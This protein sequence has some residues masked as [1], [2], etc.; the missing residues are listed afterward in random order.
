MKRNIALKM[1]SRIYRIK[2][3]ED[4]KLILNG[5]NNRGDTIHP[6]VK[7]LNHR[8]LHAEILTAQKQDVIIVIQKAISQEIVR[9]DPRDTENDPEVDQEVEIDVIKEKEGQDLDPEIDH[10]TDQ[11]IDHETDQEI[12]HEEE[13]K[14][15]Y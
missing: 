8:C 13:S 5:A 15:F 4:G 7:R 1:L 12:D 14:R 9:K 3:L 6:K 11:E 10:E 2:E